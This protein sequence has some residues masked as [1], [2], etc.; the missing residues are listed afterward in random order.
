M[1]TESKQEESKKENT[2]TINAEGTKHRSYV[3]ELLDGTLLTRKQVIKQLP[4]FFYIS[5]LAIIYIANRYHSEKIIREITFIQN[6]LKELRAKKVAIESELMYLSKQSAVAGL[7]KENE[8]GLDASMV[9]PKKITV[10]N[11]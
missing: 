7:V 9:P 1:T 8:L 4:F 11:E 5:F 6:E 3:K 2:G 10:K